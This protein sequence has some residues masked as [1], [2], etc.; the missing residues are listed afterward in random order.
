MSQFKDRSRRIAREL[1]WERHDRGTYE[2]PD[3]SRTEDELIGALEVHHK[4]GE[5]MD[6]RPE[7]HVALCRPCHNLREGKK[8]SL[9]EL[10]NMRDQLNTSNGSDSGL[11][12]DATDPIMIA[13]EYTGHKGALVCPGCVEKLGSV[14]GSSKIWINNRTC[15][16]VGHILPDVPAWVV[17]DRKGCANSEISPERIKKFLVSRWCQWL[18]NS[19]TME[20]K[21]P[22]ITGYDEEGHPIVDNAAKKKEVDITDSYLYEIKM[23]CEEWGWEQVRYAAE[24]S[25]EADDSAQAFK[26]DLDANLFESGEDRRK[27]GFLHR[28]TAKDTPKSERMPTCDSCGDY[29][30]KLYSVETPEGEKEYCSSCK[31]AAAVADMIVNQ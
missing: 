2:C 14:R 13:E 17:M 5:P 12:S 18:K 29:A 4:N 6:N 3:C 8:P 7:N 31:S 25:M 19:G 23:I 22:Q 1:Y 15:C 24:K 11:D 21:P 27:S 10:E 30:D 28:D 16:D 9:D 20:V 26:R